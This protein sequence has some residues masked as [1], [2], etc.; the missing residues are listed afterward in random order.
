MLRLWLSAHPRG[1]VVQPRGG[2]GRG[3]VLGAGCVWGGPA[4]QKLYDEPGLAPLPLFSIRAGV[5]HCNVPYL[6]S[7]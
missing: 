3:L 6:S 2:R 5:T 4:T 1:P 7:L